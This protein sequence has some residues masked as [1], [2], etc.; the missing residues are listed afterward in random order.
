MRDITLKGE[1]GTKMEKPPKAVCR[2]KLYIL[3]Y[4][5]AG[6]TAHQEIVAVISYLHPSILLSVQNFMHICVTFHARVPRPAPY[7]LLPFPSHLITWQWNPP[8]L[9]LG[10]LDRCITRAVSPPTTPYPQG[11]CAQWW[12]TACLSMAGDPVRH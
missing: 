3:Y 10:H 7:F 1:E 2:Q 8:R 12:A 6:L 9:C 11:Q 5:Q 4:L